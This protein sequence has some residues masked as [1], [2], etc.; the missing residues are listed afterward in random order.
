MFL[1]SEDSGVYFMDK[2][3]MPFI[4]HYFPKSE[5]LPLASI[6]HVH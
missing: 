1:F 3:V 2:N 4:A 5:T 6:I